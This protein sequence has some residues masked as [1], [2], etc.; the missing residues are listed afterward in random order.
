VKESIMD[1]QKERELIEKAK[2]SLEAFDQLYEYYLPKIYGYL[3]N[4]TGDKDLAEDLTSQ[5]FIKAMSKIKSYKDQ[6]KSFGAWLYGIAH[7]NLIDYFRKHKASTIF[8]LNRLESEA[9][10]EK[11]AIESEHKKILLKAMSELPDQYQEVLSLKFFEELTNSEIA[12]IVGTKKENIALK[13]HR[14]L[15]ALEKV[16]RRHDQSQI[17]GLK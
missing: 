9:S 8:D 17:L 2:Q 16:L 15:K 4:R 3:I 13:V 7:N 1:P 14:S 12:E 6:G 11:A 10:A 5:T